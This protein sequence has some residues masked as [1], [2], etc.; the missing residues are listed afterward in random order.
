M[1]S[2]CSTSSRQSEMRN[3]RPMKKLV[4]SIVVFS[5]MF[6]VTSLYAQ[7]TES[8]TGE[9][10]NLNPRISQ[11]QVVGWPLSI[12]QK[13]GVR[14]FATPFNFHDGFGDGPFDPDAPLD[15]GGRPTLQSNGTFL[16]VNGLDGQS[17]AE[18]HFIGSN[19]TI[20][21]TF[22]LGGTA[23]ASAN[24]LLKPNMIKTEQEEFNFNGR[25]INSPILFG[26]G[27]IEL[28]A[29]EMTLELQA[30]KQKAFDNRGHI[31]DLK[32]KGVFFGTLVVDEDGN[33][34][35]SDVEG[36]DED[37]IVRP[38]G[39]KGQFTTAR[40]FD[41][42]ALRF[43]FGIEPSE[44]VGPDNDNDG[45]L[46]FNEIT[47]GEVSALSIWVATRPRPTEL[48]LRQEARRG[49]DIFD[50][51]GC[52]RC[53]IPTLQTNSRMLAFSFPEVAADPTLNVFYEVDLVQTSGFR[54]NNQGGIEVP[55]FADLKRHDM[56]PGLEENFHLAD[57]VSNADF[58]TARLWGVAD[59]GPYLHDGRALTIT[60]A[61]LLLGGEAKAARDDF[62]SLTQADKNAVLAFLS[63]LRSPN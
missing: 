56:G 12:V 39:R 5:S 51:I 26:V 22:G 19:S 48:A 28:A 16:R 60:E 23:G 35:T 13:N 41:R 50:E 32:T 63:S 38:F 21:F 11:D 45:D 27:G 24:V 53:H 14:I 44:I 61:I 46:V 15:E 43:H 4:F 47:P 62:D 9:G 58:T 33:I 29:K 30:L 7:S 40:D 20:P 49:F 42:G 57:G 36:I 54:P 2:I 55:L 34:D 18:C 8:V 25:F 59:S 37:L 3:P 1:K 31:I 17:C 6:A 10:P 52:T